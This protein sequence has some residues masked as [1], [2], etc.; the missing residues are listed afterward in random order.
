VTEE[1][2]LSAAARDEYDRI[3][4]V[5]EEITDDNLA[6]AHFER[7]VMRSLLPPVEGRR[8][9]DAGCAAGHH[10]EWL[11]D[12]GAVVTAI[13]L[14]PRMVER[15]RARL[16]DRGD[17]RVHDLRDPLTFLE[18][19]S[20]DVVLSSLTIHY[21]DDLGP[22]FREFR[23]VLRPG[24]S[25]VLS[26]HHP[27]VDWQWFGMAGYYETGVVEDHWEQFGA[28][29]RFRRRTMEEIMRALE[30]AGL[31]VRRYREPRPDPAIVAL[32]PANDPDWVTK[33]TF[34]FLEAVPAP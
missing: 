3:A 12:H 5:Y 1:P 27:F 6:N 30:D 20:V 34:L 28:T 22:A 11:V 15:T 9:L 32:H 16:A 26:T 23:R 18:D 13:D 31:A 17:V 29:L 10:S 2:D 33:P 19:G 7:P 24:G 25:L 4:A 8:V 14:S 21:L